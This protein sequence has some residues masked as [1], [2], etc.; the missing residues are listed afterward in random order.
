MTKKLVVA[1]VLA[2]FGLVAFSAQVEA[3]LLPR[4][5]KPATS[6]S[7]SAVVAGRVVTKVRYR[8]DRR[9]IIA[10]F[11]NLSVANS[12]SYTL[13]YDSAG[14][15]QGA[16][17]T[18]DPTTAEPVVR[19]ILFGSCSAGICRYDRNI[20]NA[21]FVVTTILKSGKR[22]VKTFRLNPRI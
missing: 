21:K 3:K 10:T 4:A 14:I 11:T 12:I 13:T 9:A 2:L 20:T 19:E 5:K 17:G 16:G 22:V 6:T 1:V 18:V 7:S 15:T 8:T